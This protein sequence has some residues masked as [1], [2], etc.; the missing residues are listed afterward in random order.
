[1][2]RPNLIGRG[3]KTGIS[4]RVNL[5]KKAATNLDQ[6]L[7]IP[8]GAICLFQVGC[9]KSK[10][11]NF[12]NLLVTVVF[13]L[14]TAWKRFSAAEPPASLSWYCPCHVEESEVGASKRQRR[15]LTLRTE[16]CVPKLSMGTCVPKL[17]MGTWCGSCYIMLCYATIYVLQ[18]Y[19][20]LQYAMLRSALCCAALLCF[21][22]L[23]HAMYCVCVYV[24][25]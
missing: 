12:C 24:N 20:M 23:C 14:E 16:T 9:C 5:S 21:A 4:L 25:V 10:Q 15:G 18:R 17:S 19:A 2:L 7:G 22:V 6:K 13:M 1:M 11:P 8:P 3:S